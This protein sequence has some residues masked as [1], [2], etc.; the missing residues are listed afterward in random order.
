M[1][2]RI[3]AEKKKEYAAAANSLFE[4]LKGYLKLDSLSGVR[5]L[6]RYDIEDI[7]D[8]VY[9]IAKKCVFCEPPV[10]DLYEEDFPRKDGD[11]VFSAEY[12]PG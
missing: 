8:S 12:L 9:D 1:V 7:P 3:Y 11:R 2:R 5:I 4:D 6:I 10:D